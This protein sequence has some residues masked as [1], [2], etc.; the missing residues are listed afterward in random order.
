MLYLTLQFRGK[1]G[2]IQA[3]IFYFNS[4]L[5]KIV[6]PYINLRNTSKKGCYLNHLLSSYYKEIF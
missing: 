1:Y 4:F 5:T 2:I 3:P 6:H